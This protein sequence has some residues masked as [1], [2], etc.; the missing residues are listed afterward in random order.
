MK[1][2]I[3]LIFRTFLFIGVISLMSQKISAKEVVVNID[4]IDEAKLGFGPPSFSRAKV[5]LVDVTAP[6]SI[7]IIYP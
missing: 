7:E 2:N 5:K 6:I 1:N 4:N 3:Y